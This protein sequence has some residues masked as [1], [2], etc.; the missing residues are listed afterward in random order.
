M[1]WTTPL[2]WTAG[3]VVSA[4]SLNEQVRDNF[5]YLLSRP[6]QAIKRTAASNYETTSTTFTPIDATH[7]SITLTLSGSAVLLG[8]SGV[9][10]V[11]SGGGN[12]YYDMQ[13]DGVRYSPTANGSLQAPFSGANTPVQLSLLITGLSVGS[14]T[15]LPLWR[16]VTGSTA[17][18]LAVSYPITFFAVE[19]A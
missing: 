1:A 16:S 3:S 11:P 12:A 19:V 2:T 14:H 8:F 7:L 15:F 4:A 6:R 5:N 10:E 9:A 18:L 13:I 17:R